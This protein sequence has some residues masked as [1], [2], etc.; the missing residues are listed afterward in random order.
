M[1]AN[2]N[3]FYDSQTSLFGMALYF[4]QDAAAPTA[5]SSLALPTS[6][7]DLAGFGPGDKHEAELAF[8]RPGTMEFFVE[9]APL[10]YLSITAVPE[11]AS[12]ALAALALGWAG[13][14]ASRSGRSRAPRGREGA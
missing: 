3:Q 9:H 2:P 10:D 13:W 11:P 8:E 5:L 12:W 4:E 1:V 7:A 6:A 14:R